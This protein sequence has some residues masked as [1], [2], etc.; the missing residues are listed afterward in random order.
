[1]TYRGGPP[2]RPPGPDPTG[3][4]MT[5][6]SRP[7]ILLVHWHDLGRHLGTY[8][9]EGVS[10]PHVDALAA[11]GIRFD[12]AFSTAPLCSPARGSLFTGRY[13]HDNGLLGLAHLGWEYKPGVRTMPMLLGEAGYR[14]ALAGM[15]HES[16][17]PG[18]LGYDEV[19]AL[20]GDHHEREYCGPV[21]DAAVDWLARNAAAPDPF[22]LVVG[23]EETHRPYP[24]ELYPPD[25]PAAVEVPGFLPDNEWTRDDLAAFQGSIR[26]A[27]RAVGRLLDA[28]EANGVADDTW[29]VFT[30][31][32]GMAF[33]GGKSTLYDPGTSVALIMRPPAAWDA[34]CGPTDRLF[35]HVDV[36][37]TVLDL[38]G[39]PVPGE[40]QGLS[41]AAWLSGRDPAPVRR[42]VFSEKSFHDSYDPIR[43]V[44][45][46]RHKYV[47]NF[48][49]RPLLSLPGD[50]E[51]SPTRRGMGDAHLGHR[52]A[53][54]LYDLDLDPLERVN[55]APDPAHRAT[56]EELAGVLRAWQRATGDPLLDGP[57]TA[58][59]WPRQ[60]RYGALVPDAGGPW[61]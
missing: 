25:D 17:A 31:D 39:I 61:A 33:P 14:T 27:D 42:R 40:V 60:P 36:L 4:N 43:A 23:F 58:R 29:V 54:E 15:Q 59:P 30:T 28:L 37:P 3:E 12:R 48:E 22:L 47:R 57:L 6:P 32:H 16:S 13:P 56:R 10:S 2:A 35:S 51:S 1:V 21:T 34:P 26:V 18:T 24:P 38:L 8:G 5:D 52:P 45:T 46:G 11:G 9:R 53:E 19:F 44:R 50:I 49:E 55:L 41:H 20:R 7:N